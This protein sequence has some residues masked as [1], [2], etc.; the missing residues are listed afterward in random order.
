MTGKHRV[1]QNIIIGAA[2]LNLLLNA[3]LIPPFGINGA[4]TA[5]ALSMVFWNLLSVVVIKR[6]FGILTIYMPVLSR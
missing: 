5:S 3:V 4:A 2:A 1:F 6:Q